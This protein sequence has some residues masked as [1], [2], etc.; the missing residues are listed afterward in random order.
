MFHASLA[1]SL[2]MLALAATVGSRVAMADEPTFELT[3]REHRFQPER[4]DVPANSRIK[5]VIENADPTPEEFESDAL[6]R[7]K[8]IPANSKAIIYIGPLEP[9][10]YPFI[11][12]FHEDTAKGSIVAK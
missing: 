12:E 4:L 8:I 11:G 3:I 2:V 9:G 6:N 1:R 10:T 5:L 7:E